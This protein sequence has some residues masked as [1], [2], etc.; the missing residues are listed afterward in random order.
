MNHVFAIARR[1]LAEKRFVFIAAAAMALVAALVPLLPGLHTDRAEAAAITSAI[2]ATN[3]ALGLAAMLGATLVGRDIAAGRMSFYF[4]RPV[5]GAAI[6]FGKLAAAAVLVAVSFTVA[7]VPALVV[8]PR[9]LG[10]F[11]PGVWVVAVAALVL[12][13]AAHAI[14]T[15]VR[16]RSLLIIFD[17]AAA[18]LTVAI[19]WLIVSPLLLGFA[20]NASIF[21]GKCFAAALLVAAIGAGMWQL[22]DGRSDRRRSHRA[23]SAFFWMTV[24][25]ALLGAALFAIYI[26]SAS[27]ADLYTRIFVMQP[28]RGDAA[29]ISGV[30]RHRFDYRPTFLNGRR[31]KGPMWA[32]F[33]RDGQRAVLLEAAPFSG[34]MEIVVRDAARGW[35]AERTEVAFSRP[36]W[37]IVATDDARRIAAGEGGVVTVYDVD[38]GRT[39]GSFR[40]PSRFYERMFFVRPD[41]LRVYAS[42]GVFEYDVASR[43]LQKL[44]GLR[45]PRY[46][47]VSPDGTRAIA[48]EAGAPPMLCDGR[49]LHP[50]APAGANAHFLADGRLVTVPGFAGEIAPGKVLV[51]KAPSLQ[52][53]D[54]D[55][56]NV[57]ASAEG[58]TPL[59]SA[60]WPSDP[61]SQLRNPNGFYFKSDGTLVRWNPLLRTAP[62][63]ASRSRTGS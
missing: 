9:R 24:A 23:F 47:Q 8:G 46:L 27:P 3:L 31:I 11:F 4:A 59:P 51:V 10:A 39:L 17:F 60:F 13:F 1:E 19:A 55:G 45:Y 34:T 5:G 7:F 25:V 41:L 6:W 16:S 15:M 58:L 44:S 54:V 20:I 33:S 62:E 26:V 61:R 49:T 42:E 18:V 12:F 37:P 38:S 32:R 14:G 40:V 56:G 48:H 53:V 28:P 21:L 50:I 29:I 2:L 57:V 30:A 43:A 22:V 63:P 35:R 36:P 52:V